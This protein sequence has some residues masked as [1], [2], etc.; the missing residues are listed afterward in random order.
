[1]AERGTLVSRG[2]N[3]MRRF[4]SLATQLAAALGKHRASWTGR[5]SVS[6]RTAV[7]NSTTFF[8]SADTDVRC[9]L[10]LDGKDLRAKPLVVRKN[11]LRMLLGGAHGVLSYV[12]AIVARAARCSLRCAGATWR[13]LFAGA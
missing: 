1:M 6:R 11:R 2:G 7:R 5:L 8:Q 4:R 9:V 10:W 13:A 12:D 3:P